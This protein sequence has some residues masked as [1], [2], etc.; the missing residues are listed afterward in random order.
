MIFNYPVQSGNDRHFE[1]GPEPKP[2][3]QSIHSTSFR[4]NDLNFNVRNTMW[5]F[6]KK[7]E[8]AVKAGSGIW[9]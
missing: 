3:S 5:P 2:Y 6:N 8:K 7:I 9:S 4:W 1:P